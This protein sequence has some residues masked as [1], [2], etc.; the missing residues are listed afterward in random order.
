MNDDLLPIAVSISSALV[1][2]VALVRMTV[3]KRRCLKSCEQLARQEAKTSH[4]EQLQKDHHS[5]SCRLAEESALRQAERKSAKEKLEVLEDAK[6]KLVETFQAL[7]GEALKSNTESFFR[8]AKSSFE[9]AQAKATTEMEHRTKVVNR[10]VAPIEETLKAVGK[11]LDSMEKQAVRQEGALQEQ[12]KNIIA[13]ET[14][15]Q[16][17][18]AR[19]VKALR[20]PSVRGRWGEIQLKR[21]VEMAGMSA[22]CDFSE[23]SIGQSA[24]GRSR[25]RPDLVV[26]LPGGKNVVVDS[27][28]PLQSY[29]AS[30]D[31]ETEMERQ[32]KLKE[33]ARH[34]RAHLVELGTKGY[35]SQFQPAPEFVVLFLPGETFFA[36]ALEQDP[37]LIEY[38]VNQKV[39]LATP[40]TLIALLRAIA[41]GWQQE[42]LAESAEE[43]S[44]LGRALYER[45]RSLTN[46]FNDMRKGLDRSVEAY[47]R[48][49]GCL[50]SR[51]LV[52][53]RKFVELGAATGA[54]I[55]PVEGIDRAT[56]RIDL[57]KE[58]ATSKESDS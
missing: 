25:L 58:M 16:T 48:V 36:A 51:V 3:W 10:V 33:H 40:T 15:L 46:H 42:R 41:Y 1:A 27:K 19:L 56:R 49:V 45:V 44:S 20:V 26:H 18:T 50:E 12:L 5:L 43:I 6:E 30:L 28:A 17:E 14:N 31:V 35:W 7:S 9:Q 11:R 39:I 32:E 22:H 55:P 23:Q 38:G 21:V 29:L 4:F 53:A 37:S 2:V 24:E 34:V 8:L 47:N 52:T 13:A 57:P 54:E